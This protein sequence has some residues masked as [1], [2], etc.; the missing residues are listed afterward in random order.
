MPAM[1]GSRFPDIHSFK[2]DQAGVLN[3]MQGLNPHK[4]E[5]PDH[6]P[7]IF[8]KEFAAKL[9]PAMTLIFQASLQQGEVPDDWKQANVAPFFKKGDRSTAANY[10]PILLTSVCSKILEHIIH[11]QIMRHLDIHQILSDQQHGFRKKQSCESQLIL[12]VQDLAAALE[13]NEQMDAILLDFSKAFDKVSHQCLAIKLDHYGIR[14]NLLQWIK[15]SLPT[16]HNKYWLKATHPV[17]HLLPPECPKEQ[18]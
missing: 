12:T 8:L 2:V 16:E 17:L 14:G 6:I 13:E 10:R 3:L 9:S 7:T 4:A 11:S 5:G 15:A 1:S 18:S